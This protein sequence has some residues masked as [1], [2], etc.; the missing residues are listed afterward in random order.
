MNRLVLAGLMTMAFATVAQA[1]SIFKNPIIPTGRGP[2]SI[3]IGD[4]NDDGK[5]D[6]ATSNEV[7]G[8]VSILLGRG[9]ASF[10]R[11]DDL[12]CPTPS[13]ILSEDFNDDGHQDLAV[14]STGSQSF[15]LYLGL[16][17][18]AFMSGPSQGAGRVGAAMIAADFNLDGQPDI[19]TTNSA[20][21]CSTVFLGDGH[22]SFALKTTLP[23]PPAN[24]SVLAAGDLD[25]DGVPELLI[26]VSNSLLHSYHGLGDGTFGQVRSFPVGNAPSAIVILN[27]DSD[28][29]PDIA[30]ANSF[31]GTLSILLGMGG[32]DFA[33]QLTFTMSPT[34]RPTA[35]ASGN[36][37][38]L[39]SED[40]AVV[41]EEGSLSL[42][43]NFSSGSFASHEESL[44]VPDRS[45]SL[46]MGDFDSTGS[47]DL[48]ASSQTADGAALLLGHG[49]GTFDETPVFAT[50]NSPS[51][52]AVGDLDADGNIDL[53]A[54]AGGGVSV[55]LGD[56]QGNLSPSVR[57]P[58]AEGA[59]VLSLQD[60]NSDGN[61][62]V[63]AAAVFGDASVLLG[64]GD[65]T[66]VP[67]STF[68]TYGEVTSIATADFNSDGK[69]DIA[70]TTWFLNITTGFLGVFLGDG[71]GTF[72][73][74]PVISVGDAPT[75]VVTGDFNKDGRADVAV[76]SRLAGAVF[77]VLGRGNGTF[78]PPYAIQVGMG[79][80]AL[81]AGDFDGDGE[82]DLA[83]ANG[84]GANVSILRGLGNGGFIRL[85]LPAVARNPYSIATGDFNADGIIDLVTSNSRSARGGAAS[86]SVSVLIGVGDG[87]FLPEARFNGGPQP[88]DVV[89]GDFNQD[90]FP[91][92]AVA[93]FPIHLARLLINQSTPPNE[94]PIP[95]IEQ[96]GPVEC[97]SSEGAD[98]TLDGSSSSDPDSSPGTN[99]DIVSF[100]WYVD[101]GLPTETLLGS[102]EVLQATLPLGS[103]AITL[104]V[105]D[106]QGSSA[107][108]Q[109][110]IAVVDTA[111]PSLS[112]ALAPAILWPPDRRMKTTSASVASSDVCG[113]VTVTLQSVTSSEPDDLPG[114]GDLTSDIQ[115]ANLGTADFSFSLRAERDPRGQGRTYTIVYRSVDSAGNIATASSTV[116]VPHDVTQL[117][118]GFRQ[119]KR[120]TEGNRPQYPNP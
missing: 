70:L 117:P 57:T 2:V 94:P 114:V 101:Y 26:S 40:L 92:V 46:G 100:D 34:S 4:F 63:V 42:F 87:T 22:G 73:S 110:R 112:L 113:P 107:T 24:S 109:A 15:A 8:T 79:P 116:F 95:G 115:G 30:V 12:P 90:G 85:P 75:G 91:D 35:M 28:G 58:I 37:D 6:F 51:S 108:A 80:S 9:D 74:T 7:A 76:S 83:V 3:A 98:V 50:G 17:N 18:G 33:P 16:G 27:L 111:A 55:L 119:S 23:L 29:L 89:T 38:G 47:L 99:D 64:R 81:T 102:G 52:L 45:Y 68:A 20:C 13:T 103:S 78:D 106:S 43:R 71:A 104:K 82:T 56:G 19:A 72:I 97:S 96:V 44:R 41:D 21:S 118:A 84:E 31:D 86:S 48:I 93:D 105:T 65:G 5:L 53:A 49:D 120:R 14:A 59:E 39:G 77:I 88:V 1:K 25:L 66:F 10:D 54:A 62:D 69:P 11:M 32:G 60:F 36:W 61:L 67:A